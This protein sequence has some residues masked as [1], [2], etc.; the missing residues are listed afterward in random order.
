MSLK[1]GG[2][3]GRAGRAPVYPIRD[4]Q[5]PLGTR[6]RRA[7]HNPRRDALLRAQQQTRAASRTVEVWEDADSEVAGFDV[8][9]EPSEQEESG[10][11]RLAPGGRAEEAIGGN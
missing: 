10:P 4:V 6:G 11:W 3:A 9:T 8:W 5:T 1:V 2:R 7:P